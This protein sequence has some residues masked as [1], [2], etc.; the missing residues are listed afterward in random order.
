[1]KKTPCEF[2]AYK[3]I[4]QFDKNKFG[5]EYNYVPTLSDDEVWEKISKEENLGKD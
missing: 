2:C 3:P 5:N 1:M 4:C